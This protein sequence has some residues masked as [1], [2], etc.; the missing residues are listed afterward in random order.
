LTDV[1]ATG[2]DAKARY[3]VVDLEATCWE[4]NAPVQ[5][6]IIEIGAVMYERGP[7]LVADFQTFIRPL[8]QPV[9]SPFCQRL[10]QIRQ[11]DVDTAPPF[12]QAFARFIAWAREFEPYVLSSWGD[13]DR[14]QLLSDCR[15]HDVPYPFQTHVN[16]KRAFAEQHRCPPCG[17]AQ[18]LRRLGLPLEGTH[19][20]GIDDARNIARIL[21]H[22]LSSHPG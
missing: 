5:N 15:L 10:T 22:M 6:E 19:H 17:M 3:L 16:L 18:A 4:R 1:N 2:L 9:L 14:K 12:P 7:G 21:D 8:L 11:G 20:R 13:Y